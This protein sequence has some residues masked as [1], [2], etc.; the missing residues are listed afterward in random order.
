MIDGTVYI[1][2]LLT[3]VHAI[4]LVTGERRWMVEVGVGVFGPSGV[5][6]GLGKVFANKSGRR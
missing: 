2:D 1:G 6:V 3:N 5:V 4:D